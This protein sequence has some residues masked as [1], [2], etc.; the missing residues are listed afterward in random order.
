MARPFY[1]E[2]NGQCWEH[3]S[4]QNS[5]LPVIQQLS[6]SASCSHFVPACVTLHVLRLNKLKPNGLHCENIIFLII[7]KFHEKSRSNI[8]INVLILSK[9]F[10]TFSYKLI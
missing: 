4:T 9:L 5:V 2:T 1:F 7:N 10:D 8:L 3:S 6:V